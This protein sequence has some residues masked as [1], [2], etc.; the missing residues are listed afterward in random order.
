MISW[1]KLSFARL[2]SSEMSSDD[3]IG[4]GIPITGDVAR[5]NNLKAGI[6]TFDNLQE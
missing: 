4:L 3:R 1:A 6:E 2:E 5:E